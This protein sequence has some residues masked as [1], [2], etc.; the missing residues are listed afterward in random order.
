M[1]AL[2][3][4]TRQ[5]VAIIGSILTVLVAAGIYFFLIS[6]L[7][8]RYRLADD[9]YNAQKAIADTRPQAEQERDQAR[10]EVAQAQTEY[11]RY[12]RRF[13]SPPID[14]TNLLIGVQQRWREQTVVLGPK[15]L[16][17]ARG[18]RRVRLAKAGF[19]IPAPPTDPNAA[20][21]ELIVLPVGDVS[22][23]GSFSNIL[24]HA[25]RWNRFDRLVLVDD[26]KLTGN[27]PRLVGEY[28]MTC[29]IF[30]RGKSEGA[31]PVAAAAN[32][33]APSE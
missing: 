26:L 24:S 29:Y 31:I 19:T 4:I 27:S 23:V 9:K 6:P 14:V 18:D 10:R 3:K 12:E 32:A 21:T 13:F 15:L 11:R 16:R 1:A 7:M 5:Q 17:F 30:T 20:N 33:S 2:S 28:K 25:E 22:V 8:E